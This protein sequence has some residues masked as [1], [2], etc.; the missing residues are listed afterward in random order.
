[1]GGQLHW[2]RICP[3]HMLFDHKHPAQPSQV[4]DSK[5]KSQH[6][7]SHMPPYL[8]KT[9]VTLPQASH[10]NPP[11]QPPIQAMDG[12]TP[13]T[14]RPT[15]G[16]PLPGQSICKEKTQFRRSAMDITL[17]IDPHIPWIGT[18][19]QTSILLH[20]HLMPTLAPSRVSHY[21]SSRPDISTPFCE[22]QRT[23]SALY[24]F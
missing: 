15:M 5:R 18:R 9:L 20:H 14:F 12:S 8:H 1:M 4:E 6:R 23:T 7:S 13:T 17:Q 2:S 19:T 3:N 21:D 16:F 11:P 24:P 10:P 22:I